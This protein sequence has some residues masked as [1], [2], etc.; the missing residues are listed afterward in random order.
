MDNSGPIGNPD[1]FPISE[2]QLLELLEPAVVT[3]AELQADTTNSIIDL[4][5]SPATTAK[6]ISST[7]DSAIST[8]IGKHS[9]DIA[10]IQK[11][12]SGQI[13]SATGAAVEMAAPMVSIASVQATG[14]IRRGPNDPVTACVKNALDPCKEVAISGVA[15]LGA[16]EKIYD[17]PTSDVH[18]GI[19]TRSLVSDTASNGP[20][21]VQAAVPIGTL[22]D[23]AQ[24]YPVW[25]VQVQAP[26][27]PGLGT[28]Y[29]FT[30]SGMR[31]QYAKCKSTDCKVCCTRHPIDEPCPNGSTEWLGGTPPEVP[32]DKVSFIAY[33]SGQNNSCYTKEAGEKPDSEADIVIGTGSTREAALQQ[34]SQYCGPR[35]ETRPEPVTLPDFGSSGNQCNVDYYTNIDDSLSGIGGAE[36]FTLSS[37]LPTT[38]EINH[39]FKDYTGWA[40]TIA[41][42]FVGSV[43]A[44]AWLFTNAIDGVIRKVSAS[45]GCTSVGYYATLATRFTFET[46]GKYTS[47]VLEE[48]AIPYKYGSNR[49][50]PRLFPTADQATE[51]YLAGTLDADTFEA[52]VNING[53][54]TDPWEHIVAARQTRLSPGE[55]QAA[56]RRG[57]ISEDK[58]RTELRA[59]GYLDPDITEQI[60]GL[61]VALP[62][63]QD[64]IRF[65]V[66]DVADPAIVDKFGLEQDFDLKYQ[67]RLKEMG[68]AIGLDPD[69]AKFAWSAHWTIPSPQQLLEFQ[70]RLSRLPDGDKAKVK[71]DDI[72]DALRQQDIPDFW[73]DKFLAVSYRPLTRVDIRRMFDINELDHDEVVEAYQQLGYDDDNAERLTKFAEA[74]KIRGLPSDPAVR[75]W[76]AEVINRREAENRLRADGFSRDEIR[77]TL[78]DAAK[79]QHGHS[80]VKLYARFKITRKEAENRL[81]SHGL[82]P[83]VY[84][85]WLDDVALSFDNHPAINEYKAGLITEQEMLAEFTDAGIPGVMQGKLKNDADRVLQVE[86][87]KRCASAIK[88]RFFMGDLTEAQARAALS[89]MGMALQ[90]INVEIEGWKCELTAR[91]KQPSASVLCGWLDLGLIGAVEFVDRLEILGWTN[92][93]ALRI[94]AQCSQKLGDKRQREME[95]QIKAQEAEIARR[96]RELK[97]Q[98][99]ALQKQSTDNIK[100]Q[101]KIRKI[102]DRREAILLKAADKLRVKSK[103]DLPDAVLIVREAKTTVQN[104]YAMTVDQSIQAVW[105]AV[106][107]FDPEEESFAQR[108]QE[109]AQ[110]MITFENQTQDGNG[111]VA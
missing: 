96:A 57:L 37:A 91:G 7:V 17:V 107:K 19:E 80:A 102:R 43:V 63:V 65:M 53:F 2:Q 72:T 103:L 89:L 40:Y 50:C 15:F 98:Q 54:C 21:T 92:E 62:G 82:D 27:G 70:H 64:I 23:P 106:D 75:L 66:R 95:K 49:L 42:T 74:L 29:S 28:G 85:S 46:I 77:D 52:W 51:A 47:S 108:L 30:F 104:G 45:S 94:V 56:W 87:A 61:G 41:T 100:A 58:M 12:L 79:E 71:P 93:D 109:V 86:I 9:S 68:E 8:S 76:K 73:I 105:T 35:Q 6:I 36:P 44:F 48:F 16:D 13:T 33:F 22:V 18:E 11:R 5:S 4:V 1:K 32:E 88:D 25:N 97:R 81:Q 26:C 10:D 78:D 90:R 67:K 14:G 31:S 111:V 69:F 110:A 39:H 83:A 34:G 99:K 59:L 55:L 24:Q 101:N 20:V 60:Q 3:V 38:S 84:T